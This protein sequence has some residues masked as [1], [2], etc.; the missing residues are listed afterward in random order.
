MIEQD[1]NRQLSSRGNTSM[2]NASMALTVMIT[3]TL[4]Q[5]LN[6]GVDLAASCKNP[7]RLNLGHTLL[8]ALHVS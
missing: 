2:K 7:T 3:K 4:L 8:H 5:G 1:I 6:H